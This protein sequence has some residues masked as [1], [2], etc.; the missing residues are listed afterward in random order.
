MRRACLCLILLLGVG[1]SR[2]PELV[3]VRG[4]IT[5]EGKPV[6]EVVVT[7]TPLGDTPGNG[8]MGATDADGRFTLTD[9]RGT[10]GAHVGEYKVSLYPAPTA[11]KRDDPADVVSKG[12]GSSVPGIYIDPNQTP[13][14]AT[15]PAGGGFVEVSLTRSGKDAT[16]KTTPGK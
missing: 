11:A 10:T 3:P 7:F 14:R 6:T 2:K 9:V 15:V 13:V 4:R 12:G 1:C 16:A 8:A 5:L